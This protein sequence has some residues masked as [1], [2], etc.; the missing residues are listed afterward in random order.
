MKRLILPVLAALLLLPGCNSNKLDVGDHPFTIELIDIQPHKVWMDIVPQNNDFYYLV[1]V[2]NATEINSL[3]VEGHIAERDGELKSVY[4]EIAVVYGV[5]QSFEDLLLYRGS[6]IEYMD[7]LHPDTKYVVLAWAYD[8]NGKPTK[9]YAVKE[10]TTTSYHPSDISIKVEME[11]TLIKTHPSNNDG[12]F[13]DYF[14]KEDLESSG[15]FYPTNYYR[16]LVNEYEQYGFMPT[17]TCKGDDSEDSSLYYSLEPGDQMFLVSCGYGNGFTSENFQVF[18]LTYNGEGKAGTVEEIDEDKYFETDDPS[19]E[20]DNISNTYENCKSTRRCNG[21]I[22][23]D[24]SRRV[25]QK[26][27]F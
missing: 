18:L 25:M 19:V 21:S 14:S 7:Y 11:G 24:L 17:I 2:V 3:G 13:W 20:T 5:E 8:G 15:Y 10:F 9:K 12:Y 27:K 1:D 26:R 6:Y 22:G 4:E 23:F 16:L